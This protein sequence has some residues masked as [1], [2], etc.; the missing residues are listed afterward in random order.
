[1]KALQT[2]LTF[3]AVSLVTVTAT[4]AATEP[5][6]YPHK[7]VRLIVPTVP[8]SPPDEMAFLS[9]GT[10]DHDIALSQL[11]AGALA[12]DGLRAGLR[13]VAF[14]I[15]DRVEQLRAF[16]MR[17]DCLGIGARRMLQHRVSSSIY[18]LDPDGMELEIYVDSGTPVWDADGQI[19]VTN[20]ELRLD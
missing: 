11:D 3:A 18:L 6:R 10:R 12:H 2:F 5:G 17:L 13:H 16:K 7:P 4:V 1:M 19:E 9:F 14:R 20:P 15:G 8:G